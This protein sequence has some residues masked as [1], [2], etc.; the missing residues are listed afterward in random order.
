M[1]LQ[2]N[3]SLLLVID[4]QTS[5]LPVIASASSAIKNIQTLITAQTKLNIPIVVTEQYPKGLGSTV[6]SILNMVDSQDVVTKT[7]FSMTREPHILK[8]LEV[9]KRRQIVICGMESHVCVLQSAM[10]LKA[11][12]YDVYVISDAVC[13]RK[14]SDYIAAL[15]RF[16]SNKI[17]VITTEMAVFEWLG[18]ACTEIF[19]D[20]LPVLK[21]TG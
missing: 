20:L 10:A 13:S 3:E 5:L 7:H 14:E 8:I 18:K 11:L 12:N 4:V 9:S 15:E 17:H 19:R 6:H 16:R 21:S 1:L 2:A